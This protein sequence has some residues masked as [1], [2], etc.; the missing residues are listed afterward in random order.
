MGRS[1][2]FFALVGLASSS[3][4][5]C[6]SPAPRAPAPA[7]TFDRA[8]IDRDLLDVT[9]PRLHRLYDDKKYTVTQVVQWHLDRIDRY[10]GVYGAIE[11]VFRDAALAEAARQD[12][13][14]PGRERHA[15]ARGRSGACRSSSRPT[16][17]SK[18][19]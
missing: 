6:N 9:V 7:A 5:A 13:G 12:A 19:R 2:V 14:G 11:T 16:P 1:A 8:T 15:D 17:A 3:L 4:I 18:A 10:N